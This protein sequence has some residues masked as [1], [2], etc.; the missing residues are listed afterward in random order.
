MGEHG[1]GQHGEEDQLA[2]SLGT[3]SVRSQLAEFAQD[4][5]GRAFRWGE[6]DC[7]SLVL[8]GLALIGTPVPTPTWLS[9]REARTVYRQTGGL[10]QWLREAGWTPRGL[11]VAHAGDVIVL[12]RVNPDGFPGVGLCLHRS[13]LSSSLERGVHRTPVTRA[14]GRAYALRAP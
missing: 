14:G 5:E 13:Y 6:T 9:Y 11:S 8:R 2:A 4:E 7:V 12:P 10:V 3:A 1:P